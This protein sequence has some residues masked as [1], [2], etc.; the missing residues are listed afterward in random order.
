MKRFVMG[1]F[2]LA[3][4]GWTAQPILAEDDVPAPAYVVI[5]G[6]SNFAD[7]QIKPRKHAE[8]DAKAL[9]D[10][11]VGKMNLNV[12]PA[13]V[14][15]LLG[16]DAT[17]ANI[18]KATDWL[19]KTA[20]KDDMAIFAYF[21]QGAPIGE[22]AV[23]FGSDSTFKNRGKDAV[24]AVDLEAQFDKLKSQRFAAFLDLHFLGF[25][26]GKEKTPDVNTQN[27]YREFIGNEEAKEELPSRVMFLAN[28]GL[29]PSLDLENHG[30]FAQVLLDGLNGEADVEGYEPD[31]NI[32]ITEMVKYI[33]KSL[34]ELARKFGKTNEEK[35]QNP[36]IFDFQSFDFILDYNAQAH[37]LAFE[38]VE[39]FRKIKG[40]EKQMTEEGV[41][42]LNRMPKLEAKQELRKAY[43]KLADGKIDSR[44]F[45]QDRQRIMDGIVLPERDADRF[46]LI[47]LKAARVAEETYVERKST[48]YLVDQA[49]TGM[50]KGLNEKIPSAIGDKLKNIQALKDVD[51]RKLLVD[52]RLHLGKREDLD[53]NKDI[54]A[55]LHG[56]LGKLDP[57]TD[58]IDKESYQRM[59]KDTQGTFTGIGVQIR[60]NVIRD[61]LQVV[62]PII[63][64]PAYKAKIYAGDIITK[65]IRE[66]DSEGN[67][68]PVEIIPTKGMTTDQAVKK[69][70]GNPGTKVKIMIEREGEKEPKE[71]EITRGRIEVESVMGYKRKADDQWD[72]YV[73][74][75]NKIAYIRLTQFAGNSY[76]DLERVMR[77]MKETSGIKGFVLDLRFNP[78]GL[79]ESSVKISDLFIDD[80]II[81]TVKPRDGKDVSYVGK[82]S[83]SY[84]TFPMVC[85]VNGMSASASEIV[86]ACLQ[87]HGRAIVIGSRSYGKGSVQTLHRFDTGGVIKLTN[88]TYWRPSNRNIN[89]RST[90]GKDDEEWGVTPNAGFEVKMTNKENADLAEFLREQE[91]IRAPGQKAPEK[92]EFRDR[93]LETAIDYLRSQ[94]R[95][96]KT[97]KK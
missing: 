62:T 71:V 34:P 96:P 26:A 43:Q 44:E 69:I 2:T 52:A 22:R 25:D 46:A 32:T 18:D 14:K 70:L 49:I 56:M 13:N 16:K 67:P 58:W 77:E 3:L 88:A 87:D 60:K 28:S 48:S 94:M 97:A 76:R 10:I 21:G 89:K 39:K 61:E 29:K 93:Q 55:A 19:T 20:G 23:Y 30:I 86:S 92:P 50:Y 73:D 35:S 9:Y 24:L 51:L 82:S 36:V 74:A 45:A 5:V 80:G 42:L 75:A 65:I 54:D 15:L 91:I 37:P 12:D 66:V 59:L 72:Y 84:T 11:L 95:S 90:K 57:H 79:L 64:S 4:A 41:N 47:V 53:S 63:N 17:K 83:G 31:G 33:R 1:I 38:R 40:L 78:G 81:V 27:L 6:V 68:Q 8:T 7:A 85:L